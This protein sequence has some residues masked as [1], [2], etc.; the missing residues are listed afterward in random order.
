MRY[1]G[2]GAVATAGILTVLPAGCRR[3]S[4]AFVAVAKGVQD[5]PTGGGAR[6]A[7]GTARGYRPG[8][9]GRLRRRRG[10]ARGRWSRRSCRACSPA[11]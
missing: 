2:A 10:G 7:D 9:A 8:P 3:W 6:Q 5:A 11:T 4:S 1:I